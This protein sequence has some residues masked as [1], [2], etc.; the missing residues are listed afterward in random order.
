[1]KATWDD[2]NGDEI[3]TDIL[4]GHGVTTTA[5]SLEPAAYQPAIDRLKV[6]GGYIEQDQIAL[7]PETPKLDEALAKFLDEHHHDDDEVRFILDGAAIF[8]IRSTADRWMHVHLQAGDLIVVPAK[9]HHRFWLTEA[10]TIKAI[11]LF[12]DAAGWVPHYRSEP[13]GESS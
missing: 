7:S 13:K 6:E 5:L 1:M 12:K 11:R 4:K 2:A 9:R 10:K 3:D 8:Q